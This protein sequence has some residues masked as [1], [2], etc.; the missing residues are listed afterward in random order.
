MGFSPVQD[1]G[2]NG[3]ILY[4]RVQFDGSFEHTLH[5]KRHR[6][7]HSLLFP[8]RSVH[9]HGRQT[10]LRVDQHEPDLGLPADDVGEFL[11]V[12]ISRERYP[13]DRPVDIHNHHDGVFRHVAVRDRRLDPVADLHQ[14]R[15]L[16]SERKQQHVPVP[17]ELDQHNVHDFRSILQRAFLVFLHRRIGILLLLCPRHVSL[18]HARHVDEHNDRAPTENDLSF[19]FLNRFTPGKRNK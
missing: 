3:N 16:R 10:L 2:H 9:Q 1:R 8:E 7:S 17:Q 19:V 6:P 15:L 12:R 14:R 11:V 4:R 18:R 5:V 13:P